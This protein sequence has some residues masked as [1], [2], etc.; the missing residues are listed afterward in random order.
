MIVVTLHGEYFPAFGHAIRETSHAR[1]DLPDPA[2]GFLVAGPAAAQTQPEE[3]GS[4]DI[5]VEGS[6]DHEQQIA[7]FVSALTKAPVRG[8][9]SRLNKK[10]ARW[11][12]AFRNFK[13]Q[14]WSAD[15]AR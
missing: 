11:P 10:S 4:S 14:R 2:F 5:I 3:T 1:L 6:R 7:A 8:Q 15:C 13:R 12:P 9:L